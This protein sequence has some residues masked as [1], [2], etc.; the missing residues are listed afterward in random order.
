MYCVTIAMLFSTREDKL[1]KVMLLVDS[2]HWA[3]HTIALAI[4]KYNQHQDLSFQT[5]PIKRNEKHI[6]KIYKKY[7]L[8]FVL[9]WQ[10]YERVS[11]L[12]K[13]HTLV[14]I[15]S[16]H[17]WDKKKT[18]PDSKDDMKPPTRL[19]DFLNGFLRV[20]AV[21]LQL[22]N[23]FKKYG[24]E[25]IYYTPNGADTDIF[26][27]KSISRK[28]GGD[29]IVGY[30]GSKA[31]DWRKG[32]SAFIE[33]AAHAAGAKLQIAML[34]T[35]KYVTLDNM[36][37]FYNRLHAYICASSSEGF[38]LSVLEAA[39]CGC[40]IISTRVGGC[41]DMIEN[42]VNGF[43]V[44]RSV[45]AIKDKIVLLKEN[46]ALRQKISQQISAD[47]QKKWSWSVRASDWCNFIKG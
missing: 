16:Y 10:T 38:S 41:V 1:M 40:P 18:T 42:G 4:N 34:S 28:T 22:T 39:A 12:P 32:V 7:D 19:V 8:F 20:N 9:G 29:F 2:L 26:K 13:K 6:K 30:S 23:V 37:D 3:Y 11:F 27:R 44:D 43:L 5:E 24:V 33:P 45:N 35:D 17:S 15:H 25:K 47:V 31:H 14:G 21:S 36:P 46:E